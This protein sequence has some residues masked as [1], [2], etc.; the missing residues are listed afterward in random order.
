MDNGLCGLC[1]RVGALA[2]QLI[3]FKRLLSYRCVQGV[4][5]VQSV[6]IFLMVF[7]PLFFGNEL[8]E[9]TVE[10]ARQL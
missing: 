6:G 2:A 5:S 4:Q 3:S 1:L 9:V 10:L 7:L 8:L